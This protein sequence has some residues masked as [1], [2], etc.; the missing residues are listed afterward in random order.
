LLPSRE[1][2]E[3]FIQPNLQKARAFHRDPNCTQALQRI[4]AGHTDGL[5][6]LVHQETPPKEYRNALLQEE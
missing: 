3:I 1:G 6:R 4:P 2:P 5:N